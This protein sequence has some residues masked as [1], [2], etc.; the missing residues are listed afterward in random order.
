MALDE[1]RLRRTCDEALRHVDRGKQEVRSISNDFSNHGQDFRNDSRFSSDSYR[2]NDRLREAERVFDQL[3][4]Q[5]RTIQR[6][7]R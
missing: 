6:N 1:N 4:D 7:I 5:I 3:Q 2:L